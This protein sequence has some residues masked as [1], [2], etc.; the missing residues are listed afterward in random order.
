EVLVLNGLVI[1]A[2]TQ[3]FGV[4]LNQLGARVLA[5]Q[6]GRN[7]RDTQVLA[8]RIVVRG[9]GDDCG[10]VGGVAADRVHDLAGL[11]HLGRA[12]RRDVDEHAACAMQV[13]AFEQ[14]AGDGLLGGHAGTICARSDRSTH[15]GLTLLTHDRLDVFE[16]NVHIALDVDDL[17]NAG[18]G[19]VQYVVGRLEAVFLRGVFIQQVVQVLV[20]H[21]DER[22]HVTREFGDAF[23][24]HAHALVALE[25]EGLGDHADGQ[26]A[27]LLGDLGHHGAGAGTRTATHACGDEHHVSAIQC[28]TDFF[29][30]SFCRGATLLGL[31]AGAQAR[32]A[33][34]DLDRRIGGGQRLC[35]GIAADEFHALDA[36]LDH[37]GNSVTAGAAYT[38]HLDNGTVRA[39]VE[40]FKVHHYWTP[41]HI[42]TNRYESN[43]S[44]P[45]LLVVRMSRLNA[46][47]GAGSRGTS[48]SGLR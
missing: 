22:V 3:N 32:A 2:C 42:S 12:A 14:R 1:G 27:E 25:T 43:V 26:D 13:D 18:A 4:V 23:L 5:A 16:V 10:V 47:V 40:H 31:G 36:G 29:T 41:S 17:G 39:D 45:V 20:Q 6:T 21:N 46:C 19:I 33:Q 9:T 11:A 15:H 44:S 38:N 34:S 8:H 35:V 7:D 28:G 30:G 48:R 37:V 24:S